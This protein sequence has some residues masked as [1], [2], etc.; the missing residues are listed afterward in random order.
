MSG[1]HP[2][3]QG[4]STK[5]PGQANSYTSGDDAVA[6]SQ[7]RPHSKANKRIRGEIACAE[8]RRLKI[9]CDRMVPCS[10]CVKRGCASLCPNG[11]VPPGQGSRFVL[12]ATEHL[13][14]TLK[15][16]EDRMHS[17]EDAIAIVYSATS[18][19]PHPLLVK[20][21]DEEVEEEPSNLNSVKEEAEEMDEDSPVP[22]DALGTLYIDQDG[23]NRFFGPSGGSEKQNPQASS[24]PE[25]DASYL[26]PQINMSCRSFPFTP[27]MLPIAS[28]Q[29]SI[30]SFLP[31]IERALELADIFL[32]HLS[33]M[34]QIVSAQQ[35]KELIYIVYKHK[36]IEYVPHDLA[37]MLSVLGIGALVDL[38]LPPYNLEAQH[39][40]K[41]AQAALA[42][43]PV[44]P[45]QSIVTIKV[46]H[47][48]SIY[49]GM[50]G[51]ES[52]LERSYALLCLASQV[53]L[54]VDIDPSMWGFE[55]KEA[56]DRRV[57]FWN[58]VAGSLWQCLVTGRPPVILSGFI[59]CKIPTAEEES[60]FQQGEVPLGFG[61]WGFK[62][63]RECLVHVVK[64]SL[65]V[66]PPSYE[67]ILELDQRIREFASPRSSDNMSED[68]TPLSMKM[69]VRSHYK[70]LMLLFLHRA[71][72]TQAMTENPTN[73]LL[74]PHAKSVI[75]A[76]QSA[77]V[78]LQ[79]TRIQFM[80][81]PLL[82]ARVW[83]I[84]SFAF[85][86]AVVV[87]TVAIR[88]A[89]MN[90]EPT[91]LEEFEA[92]CTMFRSAADTSPR[93]ARAL[94]VLEPMLQKARQTR[95]DSGVLRF[96]DSSAEDDISI[97][98]GRPTVIQPT[99]TDPQ[100]LS[101][102]PKRSHSDPPYLPSHTQR[103]LHTTVNLPPLITPM[104]E[105]GHLPPSLQTLLHHPEHPTTFA[106][107]S[108]GWDGLFHEMPGP[109]ALLYNTSTSTSQTDYPT[110][111]MNEPAMLDDRWSY[112]MHNYGIL[113]DPR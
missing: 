98:A 14:N 25:L 108:A 92:S 95:R 47:L 46:L 103:P 83:R 89:H 65:A 90:L 82:C 74:S 86:A 17:L 60:N 113:D 40:D 59:D 1:Y 13:Q 75:A 27:Q 55:G 3:K 41:L 48:M 29:A 63:S 78:V 16:L 71:F 23:W 77:C 22:L 2:Y 76:Y 73:P 66:K 52:N 34:F 8:C 7:G 70:E 64:A 105:S 91:A 109:Q 36:D 57:Y 69:F 99:E 110:L 61:I 85:T 31:P 97:F 26:S 50:S 72:F 54:R 42:L 39:Y 33:W 5:S 53:A 58:L 9:R 21:K 111:N 102:P 30:E 94:P 87:G 35:I 11:T 20:C 4:E 104:S 67:S 12:A 38:K 24:L 10:T 18:D 100:G 6:I 45:E 37:L 81:K 84:W 28:T 56:Y 68:S 19:S 44:L 112:F 62:A 79:D 96:S 106:D 80:K 51:K 43:Q 101:V 49:N 93:A 32:E 107:L 88:G 15:K